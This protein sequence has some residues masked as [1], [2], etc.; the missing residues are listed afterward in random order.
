M[1]IAALFTIAKTWRQPKCLLG[2]KEIRK[3]WYIFTMDCYSALQKRKCCLPFKRGNAVFYN[4]MDEP[5][6][7]Y[8]NEINQA[9]KE[10]ILHDFTYM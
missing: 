1:F 10:K 4:N 2:D 5:G 6:G 8:A 9:Q 3:L 7:H